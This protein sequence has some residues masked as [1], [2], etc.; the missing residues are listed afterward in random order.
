M[1]AFNASK[2]AGIPKFIYISANGAK[3]VGTQYQESKY[4]F[5]QDLIKLSENYTII[6][7]SLVLD[8]SEKYNFNHELDFLTKFLLVPLINGG[9]YLLAPVYRGDLSNIIVKCL[10]NDKTKNKTLTVCGPKKYTFKNI[11]SIFAH[12]RNRKIIFLSIPFKL[13]KP[14]VKFLEKYKWFPATEDQL[15]MLIEGNISSDNK[16]WVDLNVTPSDIKERL[17]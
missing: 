2:T 14:L 12:N 4:K 16:V 3:E 11:L 8:S 17:V 9:K 13:I 1:S 6:R 10:Y 7:P 15:M 5:E